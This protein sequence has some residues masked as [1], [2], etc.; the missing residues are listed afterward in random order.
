MKF[1]SI[2]GVVLILIPVYA[3]MSQDAMMD[4]TIQKH[5]LSLSDHAMLNGFTGEISG[6]SIDYHS[7]SREVHPAL[8]VRAISG[9]MAIEWETEAFQVKEGKSTVTFT[10]LSGLGCSV[11]QKPFDCI[12]TGCRC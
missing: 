6:A 3:L 11:G 4:K 5:N 12:S 7:S 8:L 10:W 9:K 2:L 1:R